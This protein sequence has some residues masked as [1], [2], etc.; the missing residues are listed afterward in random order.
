MEMLIDAATRKYTRVRSTSNWYG[1][2]NERPMKLREFEIGS[3]S[4]RKTFLRIL[5]LRIPGIHEQCK[6]I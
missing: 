6:A 4:L 5:R 1:H 2:K 3:L